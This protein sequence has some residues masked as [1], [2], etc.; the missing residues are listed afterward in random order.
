[1]KLKE[2]IKILLCISFSYLVYAEQENINEQ[3]YY[4][5]QESELVVVDKVDP[6]QIRIP[7]I[8][9]IKAIDII[10]VHPG[11]K[12]NK[13]KE[14]ELESSVVNK[15]LKDLKIS[16]KEVSKF[17]LKAKKLFNKGDVVGA[18]DIVDRLEDVA[19]NNYRIK[20]YEGFIVL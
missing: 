16:Q 5:I 13:E 8:H 11:L 15:G 7:N 2:N 3:V 9:A 20:N 12:S 18:W 17:I 14:I 6:R 1:M 4:F 19:P 10:L